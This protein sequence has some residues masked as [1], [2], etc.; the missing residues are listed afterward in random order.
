[1]EKESTTTRWWDLTSLAI[2]FVLLEIVAS[3]LVATTWTP[4]LYLAQTSTYIAFVVGT[5]LGYSR[6]SR[7]I[8][9]WLSALFMI[10]MLPLQ[11]TLM[12]DQNVS[13]EGQLT[14]VA[15]RLFFS[16]SDFL[17]RR[18]VE[19]Y[20]F[21]VVIVTISFWFISSWAGFTLVR[22]QN[23]L[24]AIL[25]CAIGLLIIQNYDHARAGRLWFLAFFALMALLLLGRMHYLQN[26]EVWRKRRIFLS[27]DTGIELTSSMAVAAGLLIL[28]SWSLPATLSS[29]NSAVKTWEKVTKPWRELT[30][31]MENAV[32]ALESPSGSK[33]GEFYGSELPLAGG[34][35]L[36]D[37]VM[38]EVQAPDIPSD[39]RPPRY[40]WR[41]RSYDYFMDGQWYST[42]TKR[43]EYTPNMVNPFDITEDGKKP[44]SFQFKTGDASFSLLYSP[45]EPIHVDHPGITFTQPGETGRDIVAWHAFPWLKSGE[46]Y[47][48]D[49]LLKNPDQQQLRESGS[50]YPQAVAQKYL[51][52]PADFSPRIKQLAQDITVDAETPYDQAVAITKYLRENIKYSAKIENPPRNTDRLEWVLFD[53]KKGFCVYYA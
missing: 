22:D 16:T 7:R 19:D 37:S 51:Q 39:Q 46:T 43:D 17:G 33:R 44:A 50:D 14:S 27:Q 28:V 15:G 13:L 21:F 24:A 36:S 20:L 45:T 52:L 3:R 1:M 6:F 38:F 42:G 40:Y 8:S 11:W 26:K 25:P 35:P 9:Q 29:V 31:N 30:E 5:A 18:P 10:L 53:Y 34:W 41:G 23:Y 47:Q 2:L 49:V 48:V 4:Y 32:S 12:I